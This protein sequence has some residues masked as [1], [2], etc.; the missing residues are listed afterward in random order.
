MFKFPAAALTLFAGSV[1]CFATAHADDMMAMPSDG[2]QL[3][4]NSP[5]SDGDL[6]ATT[7]H[8]EDSNVSAARATIVSGD[9]DGGD[10]ATPAH[11][12]TDNT[13][14]RILHATPAHHAAVAEPIPAPP[15]VASHKNPTSVRWQSLLPGVM[16]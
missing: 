11:A 4:S 13:A 5:S 2:Y 8:D 7:A 14:T 10:V 9:D 3:A 1:F 16:K 15:A 6:I 12:A